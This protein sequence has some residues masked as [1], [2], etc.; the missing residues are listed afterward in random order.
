M[1]LF[2]KN[3]E[4]KFISLFSKKFPLLNDPRNKNE[5]RI[6]T[7]KYTQFYKETFWDLLFMV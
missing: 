1:H 2:E 5:F 4:E 7:F 3:S 6:S